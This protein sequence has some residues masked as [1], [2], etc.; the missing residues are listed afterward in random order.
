MRNLILRHHFLRIFQSDHALRTSGISSR[1][2][3]APGSVLQDHQGCYQNPH[4]QIQ[5]LPWPSEHVIRHTS[6]HRDLSS[7]QAGT[8]ECLASQ[9]YQQDQ[10]TCTLHVLVSSVQG[11]Q[12]RNQ[13][14]SAISSP[15][16]GRRCQWH[17]VLEAHLRRQ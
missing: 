1:V 7:Q 3:L 17:Q 8:H 9:G 12:M 15:L 4:L 16:H 5:I 6:V 11:C 10:V 2:L 13:A 14:I